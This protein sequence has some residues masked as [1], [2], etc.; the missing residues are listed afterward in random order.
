MDSSVAGWGLVASFCLIW[1]VLCGRDHPSSSQLFDTRRVYYF[2][3]NWETAG[4][5]RTTSN[6]SNPLSSSVIYVLQPL[7]QYIN[8]VLLQWNSERCHS[9]LLWA[10]PSQKIY[11][12]TKFGFHL[13]T[14]IVSSNLFGSKDV[15]PRLSV[16]S[17]IV[18]VGLVVVWSPLPVSP[19]V[20]LN[21]ARIEL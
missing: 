12:I 9:F 16:L 10:S 4:R 1:V 21:K 14:E 5:N 19:A 7:S 18:H 2:H 6:D 20:C 8:T 15:C 3:R 13:H 11:R 17:S